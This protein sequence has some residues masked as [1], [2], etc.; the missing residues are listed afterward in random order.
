[1]REEMPRSHSGDC[2]GTISSSPRAGSVTAGGASY[3]GYRT[4][5]AGVQSVQG[6][7][8]RAEPAGAVSVVRP[9]RS[10]EYVQTAQDPC[11]PTPR[12][13]TLAGPWA[14]SG[15]PEGLSRF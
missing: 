5:A 13:P 15:A 8:R 11:D 1:M 7:Q 2:G 9:F 12:S 4:C 3:S 6:V 14:S 10:G